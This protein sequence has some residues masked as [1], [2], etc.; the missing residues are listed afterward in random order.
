MG[1]H[2]GRPLARCRE[3]VSFILGSS[4]NPLPPRRTPILRRLQPP[5]DRHVVDNLAGPKESA[6]DFLA[7][8]EQDVYA[9]HAGPEHTIEYSLAGEMYAARSADGT[10]WLW[11][12]M[13]PRT[14]GLWQAIGPSRGSNA[15][16]TNGHGNSCSNGLEQYRQG[17]AR[18]E[19]TRWMTHA[20]VTPRCGTTDIRG[21]QLYG[22]SVL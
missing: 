12:N 2:T 3:T 13:P 16:D 8:E 7:E 17:V 1:T 6:F 15:K 10:I 5:S 21:A 9:G 20:H 22:S 19:C 18:P 14:S 4:A 11:H